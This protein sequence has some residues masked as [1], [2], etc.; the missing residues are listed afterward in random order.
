MYACDVNSIEK[1]KEKKMSC[2][3]EGL[4]Q[5]RGYAE[6][7]ELRLFFYFLTN[8]IHQ[9]VLEARK[10]VQVVRHWVLIEPKRQF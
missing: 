1:K 6:K 8:L 10:K 4:G 9:W 2:Q 7:V 3:F 5:A